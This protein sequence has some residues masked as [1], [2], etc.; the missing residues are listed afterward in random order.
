MF[1]FNVV[2]VLDTIIE[3]LPLHPKFYPDDQMT[4]EPERFFVS[5][6]IREKILDLYQEEIP[7]SVEVVIEDFKERTQGKDYILAAIVVEKESQ[8]PI[9]I[10]KKGNAIKQL[11]QQARNDIESFL[12][13]PVFLELRVKVRDKWRSDPKYLKSFGY[14]RGEE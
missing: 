5:E 8:K 1:N 9:V 3:Y 14:I 4:D 7:Y 12:G 6:I 2:S 11:G 13:R 10:G